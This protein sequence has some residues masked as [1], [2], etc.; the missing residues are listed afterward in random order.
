MRLD[1]DAQHELGTS[2]R[3]RDRRRGAGSVKLSAPSLSPYLT[4][5]KGFDAPQEVGNI[6][7]GHLEA[8]GVCSERQHLWL[9]EE[10]AP[11]AG[12]RR[13]D[14]LRDG[15]EEK[16]K[17]RQTVREGTREAFCL[18]EKHLSLIDCSTVPVPLLLQR[19]RTSRTSHV[20]VTTLRISGLKLRKRV[21]E[22]AWR[23]RRQK[24]R[25][26]N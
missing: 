15:K 22:E 18:G 14:S 12:L 1:E 4:C 8:E 13:H 2:S 25:L 26:L 9:L 6:L 10:L 19:R 23:G 17:K 5:G 3:L 24:L 20:S 7:D 21:S 16:K 11:P